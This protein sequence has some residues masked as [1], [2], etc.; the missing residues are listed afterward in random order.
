MPAKKVQAL[1][2]PRTV[3]PNAALVEEIE[4]TAGHIAALGVIVDGLSEGQLVEGVTKRVVDADGRETVTT[5][6]APSI[7]LRLYKE[8]R[9]HL[10]DVAK[11][12]YGCGV[13]MAPDEEAD[14]VNDIEA[15]RAKRL[16][17]VPRTAH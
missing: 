13:R 15:Q 3:E 17:G 14:A 10:L 12:A 11:A 2:A 16:A 8:E 6:T 4:R 7:W 5:E 9:K 1:G